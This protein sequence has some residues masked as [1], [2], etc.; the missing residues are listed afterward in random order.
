M[1]HAST[2]RL[3]L[4]LLPLLGA[5]GCSVLA[6]QPDPSRFFT[7]TALPAAQLPGAARDGTATVYG[8]GP[9]KLPAY[10]DR[11]EVATRISPTELTYSATD[12]WADP[13]QADVARV[14]LQN[15]SALLGTNRIVVYPWSSTVKVDYQVEVELLHFERTA[16]N[17]S[18]LTAR[19][20]IRDG[21]AGKYL[22]IKESTLTRRAATG[23]TTES[24]AALSA[25]LGDLSQ[26]V[27]SALR[28][29]GTNQQRP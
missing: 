5:A 14:L 23:A 24:V 11:N 22:V 19:W 7:L 20:G 6:P 3:A 28:T 4:A 17:E 13:L 18:Q 27:A 8:L 1:T 12:R 2:R 9:I 10:L 16:T 25:T 26:E 21:Q 29:L 15:L